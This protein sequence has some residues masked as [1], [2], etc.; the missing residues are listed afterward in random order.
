MFS[1]LFVVVGCCCLLR[2]SKNEKVTQQIVSDI[3]VSRLL[4]AGEMV[5]QQNVQ[6]TPNDLFE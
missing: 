6:V 5:A 2:C 3:L 1:A 4:G